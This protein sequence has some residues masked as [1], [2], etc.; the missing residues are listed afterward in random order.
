MPD[1][2]T[3]DLSPEEAA[4]LPAAEPAARRTAVIAC[5]ALAREIVALRAANGLTHLDV[6]CIPAKVH[7]APGKIPGL[8][9]EKIHALRPDY[10]EILVAFADCGTGGLLDR[11][12]E[13]EG[14]RRI[15]GDHCYGF[16]TGLAAFNDLHDAD[17]T[18]FYLTDYMVRQFEAL[19]I[20][21]L[22]LDRFPHLRDDYFGNYTRCL[23][24]AQTEDPALEARAREAAGR[25]G[26]AYEYRFTGYGELAGFLQPADAEILEKDPA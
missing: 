26:L 20:R 22:G 4:L 3:V 9:R 21:G 6:A 15:G 1:T 8:V 25:L 16:Y 18:T 17:P 12:L 13:E 19:I 10:D 23:Y 24:L 5:G 11:V 14:V 7:N 2:Q